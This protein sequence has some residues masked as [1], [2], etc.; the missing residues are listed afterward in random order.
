MKPSSSRW[1]IPLYV[2]SLRIKALISRHA[3]N[4]R[5]K[6][7]ELTSAR[8][9]T[10]GGPSSRSRKSKATDLVITRLRHAIIPK[11]DV[12][13]DQGGHVLH[14]GERQCSRPHGAIGSL[15]YPVLTP[16][17]GSTARS[18]LL[19]RPT[20]NSPARSLSAST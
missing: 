17:S 3:R 8:K 5:R 16:H 13:S 1:P 20:L 19:S 14:R 6:R 9:S 12:V 18:P 4:C 11:S 2:R 10:N 7:S 15:A